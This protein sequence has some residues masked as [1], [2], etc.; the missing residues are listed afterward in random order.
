MLKTRKETIDLNYKVI[1]G[2]LGTLRDYSKHSMRTQA[3]AHTTY[4]DHIS[5]C[6]QTALS[7]RLP[8]PFTPLRLSYIFVSLKQHELGR[9]CIL[10]CVELTDTQLLPSRFKKSMNRAGTTVRCLGH[11]RLVYRTLLT[12]YVSSFCKRRAKLRG[13]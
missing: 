12:I 1:P 9:V 5:A 11:G 7:L 6:T 13:L 10:A 8:P 4:D 3:D 2:F